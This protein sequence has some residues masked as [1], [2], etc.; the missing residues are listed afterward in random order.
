LCY[1][2]EGKVLHNAAAYS[3]ESIVPITEEETTSAETETPQT[4]LFDYSSKRW[5]DPEEADM[6]CF[7]F[8]F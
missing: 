4:D 6:D 8:D 1:S 2:T 7:N 3:G 5:S